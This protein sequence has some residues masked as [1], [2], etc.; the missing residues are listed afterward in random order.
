MPAPVSAFDADNRFFTAINRASHNDTLGGHINGRW[1][2]AR[3]EPVNMRGFGKGSG[4]VPK[5]GHFFGIHYH[6]V[7]L[8]GQA[9]DKRADQ[10]ILSTWDSGRER[11]SVTVDAVLAKRVNNI[12]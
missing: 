7:M 10:I 6:I 12:F 9:I 4:H 8:L 5:R 11:I 3:S 2:F 1:R